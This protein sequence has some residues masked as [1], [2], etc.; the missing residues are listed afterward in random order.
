MSD[1][2]HT[3]ARTV[4]AG[5]VTEYPSEAEPLVEHLGET[6]EAGDA[7]PTNLWVSTRRRWRLSWGSPRPEVVERW[8]ARY[9][10]RGTFSFTDPDGATYTA[11]IPVRGFRRRAIYLA[12]STT[13][14][15]TT[16]GLEVEVWEA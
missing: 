7:T 16:Y 3:M 14:A 15:G 8:R 9:A 2:V 5:G 11:L 10:A 13:A 1:I 4:V 6:H 12:G